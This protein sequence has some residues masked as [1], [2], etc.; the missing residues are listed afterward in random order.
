MQSTEDNAPLR[1][2]RYGLGVSLESFAIVDDDPAFSRWLRVTLEGAGYRCT[3]FRTYPESGIDVERLGLNAVLLDLAVPALDRHGAIRRIR[4]LSEVPI[5]VLSARADEQDT[6]SALDAGA[7]DYLV[8]PL[9]AGEFLARVRVALRHGRARRAPHVGPVRVSELEVD[10]LR[11]EV[12]LRGQLLALTPT[13]YKLL[14]LLAR[15]LGRVVPRQ[16]LLHEAWGP[17]AR[18]PHYLRVYMARLRRKLDPERAGTR[19]IVTEA[20]VGYRLLA[21]L[22]R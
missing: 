6:V 21:E 16:Q 3:E 2:A 20:G 8:K 12:Y 1:G 19:Y 10:L 9:S 13:D 15:N 4:A 7:D 17:N 11:R 5:L 14:S 18:D 22:R